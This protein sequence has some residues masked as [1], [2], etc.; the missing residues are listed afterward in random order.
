MQVKDLL[1]TKG[2]T[3]FTIG[4]TDTLSAAVEK[5]VKNNV[6]SL[7][8]LDENQR[9]SGIITERDILRK[10][11]YGDKDPH[12][13]LVQK[14]FTSHLLI[15]SPEDDLEYVMETMTMN[16]IRHLPVVEGDALTGMISIGDVVK[17]Q[18]KEFSIENKYLKDYISA[19][20]PG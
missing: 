3:V 10:S 19:R 20:Y 17:A 18:L 9:V 14:H 1:E 2:K 6:G 4:M 16:R 8:V 15:I 11:V 13:E 7:L 5:M 12:Q